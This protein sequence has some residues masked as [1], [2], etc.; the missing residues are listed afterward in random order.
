M[1]GFLKFQIFCEALDFL[2]DIFQRGLGGGEA[3]P[4]SKSFEVPTYAFSLSSHML[5]QVCPKEGVG[6]SL[7]GKCKK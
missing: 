4:N 2:L 5:S 6:I 3:K 7:F 1:S